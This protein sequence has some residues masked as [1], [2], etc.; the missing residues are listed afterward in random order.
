[1]TREEFNALVQKL[2]T[3]AQR[4]PASYKLRVGLLAV[5][6]YAYIFLVLTGLLIAFAIVVLFVVYSGRINGAL[7]KLFV[8]LLVPIFIVLRSLWVSIPPPK[9]LELRRQQVP[10]LFKLI[11]ELTLALKAPRFHRVLLN[12]EFNAAVVQVPRL[13][14]FG[15]QQ[16]LFTLGTAVNASPFP[17]AVSCGSCPRVGTSIRES[18]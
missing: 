3:Y 11:D 14:L 2:E 13:G 8:L 12:S 18:Q 5:L 10:H 17:P 16:A 6:G 4:Q 9:G 1:M 7:I 15:W